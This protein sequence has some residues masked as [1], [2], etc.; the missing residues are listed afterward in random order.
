[1]HFPEAEFHS[2]SASDG[3]DGFLEAVRAIKPVDTRTV[4]VEDPLGRTI[5]AEYLLDRNTGEA[6]VEMAQASGLVLLEPVQRNPVLAST[7]GTGQLIRAAV[8]DGAQK[9]YVGLG[10]SATND[11]G[12]GIGIEFGFRFLDRDGKELEPRGG[13][14]REIDRIVPPSAPPLPQ[15]TEIFAVNDVSNPLW[16]PS[17]AAHVYAPQ[18]GADPAAVQ[19][20]DQGLRQL[21]LCVRRDLKIDAAHLPGSGAAGGTAFGLRAFLDADFISG[22]QYIL[23]LSGARAF[24][25]E[26]Q[27]DFVC[28]GEGTFDAQSLQGKWIN[29]ILELASR[30]KLPVLVVCGRCDLEKAAW[31]KAGLATVIEISDRK[32][33]LSWNMEHAFALVREGVAKYFGRLRSSG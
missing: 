8:S 2:F 29:G 31:Q 16:G 22:T 17:G 32:Q 21:D 18:K 14:L 33:P 26:Q 12:M 11:G 25:E 27:V 1:M 28:T 7:L 3:G 13:N 5:Q 23:E 19:L 20:L 10:G 24:L 4:A 9:I 30:S 6:F 15:G